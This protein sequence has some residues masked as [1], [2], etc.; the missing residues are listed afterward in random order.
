MKDSNPL[1]TESNLMNKPTLRKSLTPAERNLIRYV[2]YHQKNYPHV[3]CFLPRQSSSLPRF[4]K[5]LE[6]ME[7]RKLIKVNRIGQSYLRWE[8]TL[9]RSFGDL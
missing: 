8:V 9:S 7:N 3:P 1:S 6:T 4:M 5:Q 2:K